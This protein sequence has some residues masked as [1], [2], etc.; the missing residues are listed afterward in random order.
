MAEMGA[1]ADAG[2]TEMLN[3]SSLIVPGPDSPLW[4][5]FQAQFAC[6]PYAAESDLRST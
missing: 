3:G 2:I 1:Q 4:A 6:R 5:L